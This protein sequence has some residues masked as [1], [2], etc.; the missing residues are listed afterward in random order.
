M[1]I[2]ID[3][4]DWNDDDLNAGGFSSQN[5]EEEPVDEKPWIT[6]PGQ[7]PEVDD[8]N[9]Q[10]PPQVGTQ[11]EEDN[12]IIDILKSKGIADPEKI[13][14]QEEDGQEV[15]RAWKDLTKEEQMNI[16]TGSVTEPAATAAPTDE[17]TDEEKQFI[18]YLR[19]NGLTPTQYSEQLAQP[20]PPAQYT[21]D[22]LT[23]E[24]LFLLDLQARVEDVTE[25]ELQKALEA[26]K[27]DETLF[28]KQMEGIRKEYQKLEDN[29][30][31][32][33][34]AIAQEQEN[35][36]WN[37]FV[38]TITDKIDGFNSVEGIDVELDDN[39]KQVLADFI[40][41]RD[42]TGVSNLGKALND[43]ESLVTIAWWALNG[44]KLV[45][46]MT[47]MFKEQIQK[48]RQESYNKGLTDGK[49]G[50]Q[51]AHVVTKPKPD[52]ATQTALSGK[53]E[54]IDDLDF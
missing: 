46:D 33:Q 53:I 48:V 39:D 36:Q 28:K 16:I 44:D 20:E 22:S 3:D 2:G 31:Q 47:T 13:K 6:H 19:S 51:Q 10:E 42:E 27:A 21:I 35:Q 54:S 5:P 40:L 38:D 12:I 14:F 43:P 1:A 15:T 24:D 29:N 9:H 37:A 32:Q 4:I 50:V 52:A 18:A 17:Y 30:R 25:E 8:P 41:E 34:E 45:D 11:E 7:E 23:D 49:K 26:A